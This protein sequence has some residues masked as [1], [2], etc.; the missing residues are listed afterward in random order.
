MDSFNKI[1][2]KLTAYLV[3]IQLM[4]SLVPRDKGGIKITEGKI[5]LTEIY[6]F[7]ENS[8]R[9]EIIKKGPTLISL[10][11][12][13]VEKYKR[14]CPPK[15][16]IEEIALS[17][18]EMYK[19][20]KDIYSW[21]LDYGWIQSVMDFSRIGYLEDLPYHAKIGIGHHVGF[22]SVEEIYL[23]SDAFFMLVLAEESHNNMH[24]HAA[25]IKENYGENTQK[26]VYKFLSLLNQNVATYSRLSI[27]SYFS[28]VEAFVN[29][30]GFDASLKIRDRLSPEEQE[31]LHGKKKGRFI[32]LENKM[33]KFPSIIRLD[34]KTPIILSDSKQ[35]REP[36]KSFFEQIKEIRDA[37]VHFSPNKE[38]IWR[39]PDDW[40]EKAISTS[41]ISI[42]VSL[43]FWKACYPSSDGPLYLNKLDYEKNLHEA[44]TRLGM[45]IV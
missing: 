30:I 38:A 44:R 35:S 1:K 42:E 34:K 20:N 27:L 28:F 19:K 41:K 45:K 24:N 22:A 33:E 23:I 26:E 25:K 18:N 9:N 17:F 15:I 5:Y 6:D 29:S 2:S 16:P 3:Y 43:E 40:L 21:G 12:E 4:M 37:S 13:L 8:N 39:K 10:L 11:S 36:F 14:L 32:S 31:L 7:L